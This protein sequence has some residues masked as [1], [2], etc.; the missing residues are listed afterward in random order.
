MPSITC[1]QI[2]KSG[3]TSTND[4]DRGTPD[5][6]ELE[7][8]EVPEPSNPTPKKDRQ[9]KQ[10]NPEITDPVYKEEKKTYSTT[11]TFTRNQCLAGKP[12]ELEDAIERAQKKVDA[13]LDRNRETKF[14]TRNLQ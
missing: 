12:L 6:G 11:V 4:P 13:S 7:E 3:K 8:T 5:G 1:C 14:R 9:P 10:K 2:D